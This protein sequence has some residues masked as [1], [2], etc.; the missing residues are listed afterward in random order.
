M[1][2]NAHEQITLFIDLFRKEKDKG[3][4]WLAA[5]LASLRAELFNET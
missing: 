3:F 1:R 2:G 4:K 5:W